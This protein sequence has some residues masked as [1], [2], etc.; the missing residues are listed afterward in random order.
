MAAAQDWCSAMR[1]AMRSAVGWD[2]RNVKS[3]ASPASGPGRA[4]R[5]VLGEFQRQ[6]LGE[7][8]E[9]AW[10]IRAATAIGSSRSWRSVTLSTRNPAATS[11]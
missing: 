5:Q 11:T 3:W 8:S 6:V 9:S 2:E 1:S 7:L 4:P 10:A